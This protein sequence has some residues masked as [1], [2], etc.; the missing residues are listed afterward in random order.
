MSAVQDRSDRVW[1]SL[2]GAW[3]G[4]FVVFETVGWFRSDLIETFSRTL[5]RWFGIQPSRRYHRLVAFAY[6]ALWAGLLAH[7]ETHGRNH[8]GDA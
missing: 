1:G 4:A 5:Q 2:C 6:V 3:L 7:L 8:P